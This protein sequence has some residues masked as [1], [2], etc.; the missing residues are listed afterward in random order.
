MT[1]LHVVPYFAPAWTFGG[2]CRAV[3]GLARAQARM[4]HRPI[5]LTTDVLNR[6]ARLPSGEEEIDGVRV[7]RLRNLSQAVRGRLNLSTPRGFGQALRRL[8]DRGVAD[9]V[10]CHELR[11]V[12]TA[13]AAWLTRGGAALVLSPHGT[14]SYATG[15]SRTKRIWDALL[16]PRILPAFDHVLA[17]TS[18]EAAEVRALWA[19]HR[20]PLDATQLSL[21]PNGVDPCDF[22]SSPPPA[23]ARARWNL[24]DGPVIL[25]MG[26][27]S[28]RKGL[29]ILVEAFA[30]VTRAVP[31]ARLLVAG[32]DEGAGP[33]AR[34][35]ARDLGV[36]D[37]VVFAG[38]LTGDDRFAALA[39]ADVFALPA[40]GEGFSV[41]VLEA[42]ASGVPA[43][44][45]PE[46]HFPEVASE[47]AGLIAERTPA[48]WAAAVRDLLLDP[49]RRQRMRERARD[50]VSRRYTWTRIAAD[51]D[52]AY[53][54]A[55]E[56]RQAYLR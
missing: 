16:A 48:V 18:P 30:G 31:H 14:L 5:V 26:R 54:S 12:E 51:M 22:A 21:V 1:V 28:P 25:F 45:S 34:A 47:G 43:V 36:R 23:A 27:L 19:R 15:R 32:P 24:G 42:L 56:W 17:L 53:R 37:Q 8:T 2:V 9:V 44:L 52:A 10:H 4:G 11:T 46:C 20:V 38:A 7:I 29:A 33:P 50:L 41:A 35:A 39:A 55:I 40:V 13:R 3:T 49:A 6:S